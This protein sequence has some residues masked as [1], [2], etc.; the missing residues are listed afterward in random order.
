VSKRTIFR[1]IDALSLSG[2]PVYAERGNKGGFRLMDDFVLNKSII[3]EQEQNEILSAL[4]NLS[5]IKTDE[6]EQ[7]LAKF[8]SFFKKTPPDW[9]EVDISGWGDAGGLHNFPD[10]KT[11]IIEKHIIEFEYFNTKGEKGRRRVEPIKLRFKSGSWYLYGFC[12]LRK[13]TRLFKLA[14]TRNLIVTD[15]LFNERRFFDITHEPEYSP[16][17]KIALVM[18]IS[19]EMAYRV[20]DYCMEE[21]I[22]K[23][24]DGSLT[25][26]DWWGY[27][28][29]EMYGFILSFG[30]YAEV[31]EP[32]HIR[33][34]V[35]EKGL[36]IVKKYF[37]P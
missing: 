27:E 21:N 4:Q 34:N 28:S 31:L 22:V 1:D 2:I 5:T 36:A 18:K 16:T 15:E 11:A 3:T 23:N 6:A 30:E 37:K 7:A 14:R 12:L 26:T 25:V 17:G 13:D 19:P 35:F 20:Y 10:M 24:N 29:G 8:R 32:E 33:K 9:F